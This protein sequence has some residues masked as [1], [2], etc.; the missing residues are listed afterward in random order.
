MTQASDIQKIRTIYDLMRAFDLKRGD[1]AVEQLI[2][3][4][5]TPEL[6]GQVDRFLAGYTSEDGF[7]SIFQALPWVGLIHGLDQE[8]SPQSSKTELQVPDHTVFIKTAMKDRFTVVVDPKLVK[9]DKRSLEIIPKQREAIERYAHE[10]GVPLLY[11]IFWAKY[12][13]WTVN[14]LD[15]FDCSRKSP[16]IYLVSG[17]KAACGAVCAALAHGARDAW[18][19]TERRSGRADGRTRPM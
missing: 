10:L 11:P 18:F 4:I 5:A 6:R 3:Q 15:Q 17:R 8:Q 2:S 14:S 7:R 1:A 13:H 9:G 12:Q 16:R 19:R